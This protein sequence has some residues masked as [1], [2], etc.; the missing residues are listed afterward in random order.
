[1]SKTS[2]EIVTKAVPWFVILSQIRQQA[3]D[4]EDARL[5]E[6]IRQHGV[7]QPVGAR[8][9][10]RLIWGHRRV[11]C[12]IAA[13]L[14]EVP[15]V[16]LPGDMTEGEFLTLQML[17]NVQRETLSQYDL[18]QGCVRLL[19]A[20][21]GWKLQD[22]AKALSLD[23]SYLTKVLSPSKTIPAA[24]EALKAGKINLSHSYAL[25][26]VD[27]PAEQE[28]L[29]MLA[30]AGTSREKLEAEVKKARTQKPDTVKLSRV[31]CA[32]STGTVVTVAGSEMDLDQL[33]ENLEALLAAARKAN[34]DQ[35]DVRT[36]EKVLKDKAKAG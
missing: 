22:L 17:E 26:R 4:E 15:A 34:R 28:R 27:E 36:F 3:T 2:Y 33:I 12:A 11:R 35:L 23:P 5:T 18:W 20:N 29:L 7:L 9:D 8:P 14:T 13:G 25:S 6:S 32:L 31:K 10:G 21:K 1:M 30:L 24:V 16:I 19:E